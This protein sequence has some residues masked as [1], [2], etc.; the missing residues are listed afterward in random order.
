[1]E[2]TP[3]PLQTQWIEALE[4]G[5]FCQT[6]GTLRG[7][8]GG[9]TCF[10]CLGVA[11]RVLSLNERDSNE[12]SYSHHRLGLFSAFGSA[13][14]LER[15]EELKI[16]IARLKGWDEEVRVAD[17]NLP[18]TQLNDTL[19]LSFAQIAQVLRRFPEVYFQESL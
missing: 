1:M 12:L 19:K 10:C 16:F 18:L 17:E 2:V 4:S 14:R 5:D 15:V 3:G 11:D 9:L 7:M 8:V 13:G 6:R